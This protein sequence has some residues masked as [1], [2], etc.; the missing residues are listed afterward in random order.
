MRHA[1]DIA[2]L[3]ADHH[4]HSLWMMQSMNVEPNI[5]LLDLLRV[6]ELYIVLTIVA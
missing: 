6:F 2:I 3:D 1:C 4:Q 5:A